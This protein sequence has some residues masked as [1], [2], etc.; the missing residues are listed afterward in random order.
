MNE[1][2]YI[3]IEGVIGVGKTTLARMLAERLDGRL[4]LEQHEQNPFLVDFYQDPQRFAFQTELFFLLNRYR[5]Q[6]EEVVQPDLFQRHL[7]AD[8]HFVKNRIFAGITLDEREWKL[9]EMLLNLLE[10]DVAV[11]DLVVYLQSNTQRLIR[12]IRIR[13]REYERTMNPAYIQ[14]LVESY[15]HFFFRYDASP[16][17]VVNASELDFI[18]NEDQFKDLFERIMHAPEGTT[19]YNPVTGG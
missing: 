4:I 8:Y 6:T 11:P 12:N 2:Q 19:Y 18:H 17:L 3:V 9:Y 7:I 16:L 15:N 1:R 13:D 10:R 5:Q 14:E